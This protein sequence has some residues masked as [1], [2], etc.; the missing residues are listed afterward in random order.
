ML[1]L[2]LSDPYA[3]DGSKKECQFLTSI[4]KGLFYCALS[5]FSFGLD[6]HTEHLLLQRRADEKVALPR[7]RANTCCSLPL[8]IQAERSTQCDWCPKDSIQEIEA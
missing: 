6:L 2:D 3:R 8:V 1:V 5:V 7:L 4:N